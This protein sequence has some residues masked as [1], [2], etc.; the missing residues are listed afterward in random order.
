MKSFQFTIKIDLRSQ[1]G[2]RSTRRWCTA[3]VC[4][5]T[6]PAALPLVCNERLWMIRR[7]LAIKL[8][9]GTDIKTP[10]NNGRKTREIEA[11]AVHSQIS[12]SVVYE[13]NLITIVKGVPLLSR[14]YFGR[15]VF[16]S[17]LKRSY[18]RDINLNHLA[19]ER[20]L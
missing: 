12:I 1:L 18:E 15:F 16:F 17:Q 14:C 6:L 8:S 5:L 2:I 7:N 4:F 13:D 20:P 19:A 11:A 3:C 9:L 10:S